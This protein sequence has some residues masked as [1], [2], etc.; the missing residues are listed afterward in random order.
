MLGHREGRALTMMSPFRSWAG[1][2]AMW[3]RPWF[4]GPTLLWDKQEM[5]RYV[6][7]G[8]HGKNK[9]R[10][11]ATRQPETQKLHKLSQ[12][13]QIQPGI[14]V[15]TSQKER[16]AAGPGRVLTASGRDPGHS[17]GTDTGH[18]RRTSVVSRGVTVARVALPRVQKVT[19]AC[20]ER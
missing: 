3:T 9:F 12:G 14:S 13:A 20:S 8:L 7:A 18:T 19:A 15:E 10:E 6:L 5:G 1:S 16:K 17:Q 11:K 4:S 2:M